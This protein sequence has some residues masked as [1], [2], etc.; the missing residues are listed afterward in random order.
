MLK[1][2]YRRGD[3]IVSLSIGWWFL[4]LLGGVTVVTFFWQYISK[5][6]KL[7]WYII[8]QLILGIV[9]LFFFNIFGQLINTYIPLNIITAFVVGIFRIPGLI[10]LI[11]IKL[12]IIS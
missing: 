4:I 11:I 10:V 5:F 9:I 2:K 7:S 3:I 1:C 8:L 6:I 12:F